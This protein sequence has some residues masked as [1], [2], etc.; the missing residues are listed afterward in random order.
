[1]TDTFRIFI[2]SNVLFSASYMENH[3]FLIFW[4]S[5]LARAV[6]WTYVAHETRR[7][8]KTAAHRY[9][10]ERLLGQSEMV[11]DPGDRQIEGISL[12]EK[13]RPILSGALA[14]RARYLVTGD[15]NH[16]GAYFDRT[17]VTSYGLLA[18]I[19]PVALRQFLRS[20]E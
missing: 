9:R 8:A 13:D 7:N 5:E 1:M 17:F 14:A 20:L 11:D 4:T 6:T 10:L 2:D 18:I 19:E 15:K 12:P 16:F 3:S